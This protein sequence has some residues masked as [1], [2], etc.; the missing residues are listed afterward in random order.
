MRGPSPFLEDKDGNAFTRVCLLSLFV[1]YISCIAHA[2]QCNRQCQTFAVYT[3]R[4]ILSGYTVNW[5][6][7]FQ[8]GQ[9]DLFLM[10]EDL[11]W[12]KS[13]AIPR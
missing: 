3:Y 10:S 4:A 8:W 12:N 5:I 6:F 7:T 11:N 2:D 13:G 9:E 1:T